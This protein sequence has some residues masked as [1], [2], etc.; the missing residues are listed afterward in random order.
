MA[1]RLG[2]IWTWL[3]SAAEAVFV[4]SP[5]RRFVGWVLG[6]SLVLLF[7]AAW[8]VDGFYHCDEHFQV[9]E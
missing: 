7:V 2:Q 9:L 1:T 6:L 4:R 3:T 8:R 5:W